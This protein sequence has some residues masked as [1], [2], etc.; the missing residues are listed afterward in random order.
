MSRSWPWSPPVR[1]PNNVTC[2][3]PPAT[4]T[5]HRAQRRP[6][7]LTSVTHLTINNFEQLRPLAAPW[8]ENATNLA[9]QLTTLPAPGWIMAKMAHAITHSLVMAKLVRDEHHLVLYADGAQQNHHT[10]VGIARY[11]RGIEV[12]RE[13]AGFNDNAEA[14]DADL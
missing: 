9:S 11:H 4:R 5:P 2:L 1:H 14:Y 6:T 7:K 8:T 12:I 13:T 3:T 10:G